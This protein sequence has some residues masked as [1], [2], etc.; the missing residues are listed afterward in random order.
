M[1]FT[2]RCNWCCREKI[3]LPSKPFCAVCSAQGREC[4]YCH[5]PMPERF[6]NLSS[7]TC[8]SCIRKH[9]KQNRKRLAASMNVDDQPALKRAVNQSGGTRAS[10]DI[11]APTISA[12]PSVAPLDTSAPSTSA[13]QASTAAQTPNASRPS[14]ATLPAYRAR[15][16][17]NSTVRETSWMPTSRLDVLQAMKEVEQN[18]VDRLE[19]DIEHNRGVKWSL[20]VSARY[21]KMGADGAPIADDMHFRFECSC[22]EQSRC[23]A[24]SSRSFSQRFLQDARL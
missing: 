14:T 3:L 10:S 16:A 21:A 6:Y 2:G 24:T 11:V 4:S 1:M 15:M 7:R 18:I 23:L 13:T 9:E 5:R 22:A 20:T 17:L 12:S 8:N 19:S